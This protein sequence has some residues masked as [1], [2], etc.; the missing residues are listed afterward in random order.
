[1]EITHEIVKRT[2]DEDGLRLVGVHGMVGS[3]EPC[4]LAKTGIR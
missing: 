3:N 2:R 1:V 4:M